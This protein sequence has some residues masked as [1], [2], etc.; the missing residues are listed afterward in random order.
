R[1]TWGTIQ[2]ECPE[3]RRTRA[4]LLQGTSPSKK[5]TNVTDVKRYLLVATITKD[6]LLVVKRNEP[7]VPSRECIIVPRQVLEGLL[8][9]LHIRLSHPSSHQLKVVV[10][11]YLY[12]LD[13]DKVVN[14]VS[15]GCHHYAALRRLLPL[16]RITKCPNSTYR[17]VVLLSTKYCWCSI[18]CR[19][20]Q[21][22]QTTDPGIARVCNLTH[23]YNCSRKRTP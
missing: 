19:Y 7:L 13:V 6:G 3:L 23:S 11:R 5:L 17:T 4:R 8:T 21:T 2:A 9:A 15:E 12:A 16:R 20:R 1:A 10:K 18:C 22:F 14:R